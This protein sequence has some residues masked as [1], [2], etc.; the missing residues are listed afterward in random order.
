MS[1]NV[2]NNMVVGQT[3]RFHVKLYGQDNVNNPSQVVDLT[4]PLTVFV[5]AMYSG[6]ISVAVDPNDNRA[7]I[8]TALGAGTAQGTIDVS[9]T[10]PSGK[11][12]QFSVTVAAPPPDN[13]RMDFLTADPPQ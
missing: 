13:R 7:L 3:Q 6:M 11:N 10:L 2:L 1:V 9:P 5:Q 4:T 8:V 12:V